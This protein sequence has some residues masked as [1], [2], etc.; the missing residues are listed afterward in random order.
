MLEVVA[1]ATAS[2]MTILFGL[3]LIVSE[4]RKRWTQVFAAFEGA[5]PRAS[6]DPRPSLTLRPAPLRRSAMAPA[7]S[8]PYRLAA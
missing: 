3:A 5:S 2:A 4:F 1:T 7:R 8:V 6:F